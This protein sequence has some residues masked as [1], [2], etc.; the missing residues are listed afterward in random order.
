[1]SHLDQ[2]LTGQLGKR[3]HPLNL[4]DMFAA[5]LRGEVLIKNKLK[6]AFTH[7]GHGLEGH[8]MLASM[9]QYSICFDTAMTCFY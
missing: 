4:V 5:A 7:Y 9:D 3:C 8:S 1:M 6:K 2:L